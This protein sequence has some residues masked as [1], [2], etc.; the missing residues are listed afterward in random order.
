MEYRIPCDLIIWNCEKFIY[1]FGCDLWRCMPNNGLFCVRIFPRL[2]CVC[3]CIVEQMH[4]ERSKSHRCANQLRVLAFIHFV[5][6]RC[7]DWCVV[8]RGCSV[9]CAC[10]YVYRNFVVV[11]LQSCHDGLEILA[12][13]WQYVSNGCSVDIGWLVGSSSYGC[14]LFMDII[15]IFIVC[16]CVSVCV[17]LRSGWAKMNLVLRVCLWVYFSYLDFVLVFISVRI[18]CRF[19][20]VSYC[21]FFR[22]Q[23][24]VK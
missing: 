17:L 5:Y 2:H 22:M 14:C 15:L 21:V 1:S 4:A 20:V 13:R 10:V 8:W 19:S 18:V 23:N 9:V 12:A 16:V 24:I 6:V 3:V 7:D 11:V